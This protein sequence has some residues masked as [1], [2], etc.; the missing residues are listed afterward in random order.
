MDTKQAKFV[1]ADATEF[2]WILIPAGA[3][4]WES[5]VLPAV[6]PPLNNVFSIGFLR[7]TKLLRSYTGASINTKQK[8]FFQCQE[9]HTRSVPTCSGSLFPD[10]IR[11][12]QNE[13]QKTSVLSYQASNPGLFWGFS[14]PVLCFKRFVSVPDSSHWTLCILRRAHSSLPLPVCAHLCLCSQSQ[15]LL[16]R[17]LRHF[18]SEGKQ[19]IF[20]NTVFK[21]KKQRQESVAAHHFGRPRGDGREEQRR[22]RS[23][24]KSTRS[25]HTSWALPYF[26]FFRFPYFGGPGVSFGRLFHWSLLRTYWQCCFP[27][28]LFAV[29]DIAAGWVLW[30]VLRKRKRKFQN[31]QWT[32]FSNRT[33]MLRDEWHVRFCF[34]HVAFSF[35]SMLMADLLYTKKMTELEKKKGGVWQCLTSKLAL[36]KAWLIA[37]E[38]AFRVLESNNVCPRCLA[39]SSWWRLWPDPSCAPK[40]CCEC[41]RL[42]DAHLF[43]SSFSLVFSHSLS[44]VSLG[45]RYVA[46]CAKPSDQTWRNICR[47]RK[48]ES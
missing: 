38:K 17:S 15:F 29:Y 19:T 11:A 33:V 26:F 13:K 43:S 37:D 46:S 28:W 10:Q 34:I 16:F 14:V 25:Q 12:M 42:G 39:C 27:V 4:I 30:R 3:P 7:C 2:F 8:N 31:V 45:L 6:P 20:F 24:A 41:C 5:N 32:W 23:W 35:H 48:R 47:E 18:S 21:K 40:V 44:P 22:V 1:W 9:R 36:G